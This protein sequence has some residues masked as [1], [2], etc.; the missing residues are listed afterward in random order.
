VTERERIEEMRVQASRS[1]K[2]V[3]EA[4]DRARQ[5]LDALGMLRPDEDVPREVLDDMVGGLWALR[6]V[7]RL[8]EG[9]VE[10][11]RD[12]LLELEYDLKE[13]DMIQEMARQREAIEER[14]REFARR[15]SGLTD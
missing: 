6:D 1:L 15:V 12:R 11:A 14:D 2:R 5:T 3:S 9:Q 13:A 7:A 10:M 8:L 4:H